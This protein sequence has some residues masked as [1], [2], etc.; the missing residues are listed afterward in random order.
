MLADSV[1][2]MKEL[3]V[4]DKWGCAESLSDAW[5]ENVAQLKAVTPGDTLRD[6]HALN[7]LLSDS[8]RHIGQSAGT[9]RH[10]E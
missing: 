9:G 1:P 3:S 5:A 10:A 8:W 6:A 4:G 7:D 2:E